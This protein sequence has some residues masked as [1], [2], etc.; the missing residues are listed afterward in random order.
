[1]AALTIAL[2]VHLFFNTL[3][4]QY[5]IDDS[6]RVFDVV[7]VPKKKKKIIYYFYLKTL[8]NILLD[9]F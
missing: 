3:P 6:A 9:I 1:M 7:Y 2:S 4:S 8:T 5:L